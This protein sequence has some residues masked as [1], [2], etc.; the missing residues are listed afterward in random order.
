MSIQSCRGNVPIK[1]EE[2]C[3]IPRSA[4]SNLQCPH[5]QH[6]LLSSFHFWWFL[7]RNWVT[8]LAHLLYCKVS[9]H[10]G[11]LIAD[12]IMKW[13][14]FEEAFKAGLIR[15]KSPHPAI[16]N[17]VVSI[18]EGG[19]MRLTSN[20]LVGDIL[21]KLYSRYYIAVP[22]FMSYQSMWSVLF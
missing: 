9:S 13:V 22:W 19:V 7:Q 21:I 16:R 6:S 3:H 17:T 8:S 15:L 4:F 10:E 20:N 11:L 5:Q 1:M 18:V 14:L 2:D 12:V